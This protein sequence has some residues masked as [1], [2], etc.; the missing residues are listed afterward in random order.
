[1]SH[2]PATP[3]AHIQGETISRI[4]GAGCLNQHFELLHIHMAMWLILK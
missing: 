4:Q 2:V 3:A 1:M